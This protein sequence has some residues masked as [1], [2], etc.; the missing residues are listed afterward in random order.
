MIVP[1]KTGSHVEI[2]TPAQHR[3]A[4]EHDTRGRFGANMPFE[5]KRHG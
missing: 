1:H 2:L 4:Q 5:S 3:Y